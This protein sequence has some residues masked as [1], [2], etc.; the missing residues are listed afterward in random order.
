MNTE[1]LKEVLL[2]AS[3][4]LR[5]NCAI[6]ENLPKR[7]VYH[8]TKKLMPL[9]EYSDRLVP[10]FEINEAG[11]KVPTG[12]MVDEL[13]PGITFDGAGSGGLI[14]DSFYDDSVQRLRAIEE[15]VNAT[16]L[17]PE[18][19]IKWVP[20]AQRPGDTQSSPRAFSTV[21]RVHLPEP[22]SPSVALPAAAPVAVDTN[23]PEPQKVRKPM[24]E[25]HKAKLREALA[26]AREAKLAKKDV[27]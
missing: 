16:I 13:L 6:I 10:A 19:R 12:E 7:L 4:G 27:N 20:Y 17:D 15:Y 14:F 11:K 21:P 2:I 24:S 18:K 22:E 9:E 5:V 3:N 1:V 25:E 23:L 8:K 26:R